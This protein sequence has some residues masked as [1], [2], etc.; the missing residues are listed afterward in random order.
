[1]L[2]GICGMATEVVRPKTH[3]ILKPA[4]GH[5]RSAERHENLGIS[6]STDSTGGM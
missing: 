4:T 1:V 6:H 3:V 2:V 5:E